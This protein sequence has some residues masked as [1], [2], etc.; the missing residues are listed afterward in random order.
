MDKGLELLAQGLEWL[1]RA[2]WQGAVLVLA[3]LIGQRLLR[4]TLSARWRF[5]LW[6]LVVA[7]LLLPLSAQS[8]LS[9]FNFVKARPAAM[10]AARVVQTTKTGAVGAIGD[11]EISQEK[12]N[13]QIGA[14]QEASV[15]LSKMDNRSRSGG[16]SPGLDKRQEA[17]RGESLV[18][19]SQFGGDIRQPIP[20]SVGGM[21]A[22]AYHS[23]RKLSGMEI[24]GLVWAGVGGVLA[25]QV[26]WL[27]LRMRLQIRRARPV[28]ETVVLE[29]FAQCRQQMGVKTSMRLL[30]TDL[31]KSPALC[32]LWRPL[33]LLPPGL[34][35]E[36]SH[37]ELRFVFLHEL[38]HA[39]RKD[40]ALNWLITLLQIA[41]WFNPLIWFGFARMRADREMACDELAIGSSN[42]ED[43]KAYGLT[44][45]KLLETLSRPSALPGL[46]G[47]M[48]DK[49][50]MQRRI[51]MIAAFKKTRRWS[52]PALALTG[53]L[54]LTGLTD[55]VKASSKKL[56]KAPETKAAAN[57]PASKEEFPLKV[58]DAV[59]GQPVK[60]ATVR[61]SPENGSF[62]PAKQIVIQTSPEGVALV[63]WNASAMWPIYHV[64]HPDY[65][66]VE[67]SMYPFPSYI[68][69]L[70]LKMPKEYT[71]KLNRGVEIGGVVREEDGS[72]A[73]NVRVE[74]TA[75]DY[76]WRRD[77]KPEPLE[78]K[79][80][81][82]RADACPV[83]DET[84]HWSY[85]HFPKEIGLVRMTLV[86]GDNS[87]VRFH[88][89]NTEWHVDSL[90]E[91]VSK[92][93]L[94]AR[95]AQLVLKKG[96]PVRGVVTDPSGN[97]VANAPITALDPWPITEP[98]YRFKTDENGRFELTNRDP[99][100]ILLMVNQPGF[101]MKPV[102]VTVAPGMEELRIPLAPK[103]P[104]R[105]K[106]V[107]ESGNPIPGAV[108]MPHWMSIS[109]SGTTG[110]DGR[111]VLQNAPNEPLTYRVTANTFEEKILEK[112]APSDSEQTIQLGK[113]K[114]QGVQIVVT[115]ETED[116]QPVDSFSVSV[117]SG[118][119]VQFAGK[120]KAGVFKQFVPGEDISAGDFQ[121]KI[122]APGREPF[123]VSPDRNQDGG[124]KEVTATL[125]KSGPLEGVVLGPDGQPTP[126]ATLIV[127]SDD[128][129][130]NI[131]V[132]FWPNGTLEGGHPD[133]ERWERTDA[134]GRYSFS[135]QGE[136]PVVVIADKGYAETSLMSLAR[137]HEVR[138]TPWG[139]LEGTIA[140]GGKPIQGARIAFETVRRGNY[141]LFLQ[142]LFETGTDGKFD[143]TKMPPGKYEVYYHKNNG[144]SSRNHKQ[145]VEIAAG[146]T[147]H[148]DYQIAGRTVTGKIRN[149]LAEAVVDWRQAPIK[150]SLTRKQSI[151]KSREVDSNDYVSWDDYS[152]A[153]NEIRAAS[154]QEAPE[155]YEFEF[156][157][158]GSFKAEGVS[159]GTYIM[160]FQIGKPDRLR[161]PMERELLATLQREVVVPP[162]SD[163]QTN[164]PFDLGELEMR[165]GDGKPSTPK[166]FDARGRDGKAIKLSDFHGKVT[167]VTFWSTWAPPSTEELAQIQSVANEFGANPK[168]ALLGTNLDTQP[169][170]A[171]GYL[172]SHDLK[173]INAQLEGRDRAR[174][175]EN[176]GIE[177]L[178]ATFLIGP[179]GAI[180]ARDLKPAEI[181]PAI[182]AA[183]KRIKQ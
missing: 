147:T 93:D 129:C 58:L 8:A 173:W 126:R 96:F 39:R 57:A 62:Y 92:S 132:T 131:E 169:G 160:E 171:E 155:V 13:A 107:D 115:A 134:Q 97:P 37:Q 47:I 98:N 161:N 60:G 32:G 120:S 127:G 10:A 104:L 48:E 2:S 73:R 164:E 88:T 40:V 42:E 19:Q 75:E 54:A 89:G 136:R 137:T 15:A 72:P 67:V 181:R 23:S 138:L 68:P 59:T 178:P 50:Q 1:L 63:P 82:P 14:G 101:A 86:R 141:R 180:A 109:W 90:E 79:S 34:V 7:R 77:R 29:L 78:I 56:P 130:P 70:K 122:E 52:L 110:N 175:P 177:A 25:A 28:E 36:F 128:S 108:L 4:G 61:F 100:Q 22:L 144:W 182:E 125:R 168:V 142:Y 43:A 33:L 116:Q 46:V 165:I 111:L 179:D 154:S 5:N 94:Y 163:S 84:G 17:L 26:L 156:N 148:L 170:V 6:L 157:E 74:I 30:E 119:K 143:F 102:I 81:D 31:V 159:P 65:A 21:S 133:Q 64:F 53:V 121:L 87:C 27:T 162:A 176:W 20:D 3:V 99:H 167:L 151:S 83:T 38:A 103:K 118:K 18:G 45:I 85:G 174:V 80:F 153:Y 114:P 158:D 95:K 41:H 71:V 16:S 123:L 105:I 183:L 135:M 9:L 139:R 12:R 69:S 106:V 24:A 166:T 172:K 152:K 91:F 35:R 51:R 49:T 11:G 55:A 117:L 146:Q 44:I 150:K 76:P 112:L 124:W 145:S 113:A 149:T 140:L 66:P